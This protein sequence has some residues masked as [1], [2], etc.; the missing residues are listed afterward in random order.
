MQLRNGGDV[1]TIL[2][3]LDHNIKTTLHVLILTQ[4]SQQPGRSGCWL[5]G[6]GYFF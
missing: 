3:A 4:K 1:K 6:T 2:V 5:L